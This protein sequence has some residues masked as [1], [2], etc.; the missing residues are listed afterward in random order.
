MSAMTKTA[1]RRKVR[2]AENAL[3]GELHGGFRLAVRPFAAEWRGRAGTA[4]DMLADPRAAQ[5]IETLVADLE[6]FATTVDAELLT[7]EES[8]AESGF[9][10]DHLARLCREGKLRNY[11][12][13]GRP[14]YARSELPR[15]PSGTRALRSPQRSAIVPGTRQQI[16]RAAITQFVG[17]R[18]G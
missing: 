4:R 2:S 3:G 11:G 18:D 16:A 17:G 7:P 15:K 1:A 9:S 14:L 6:R 8:H 10:V 13:K 5:I 12:R